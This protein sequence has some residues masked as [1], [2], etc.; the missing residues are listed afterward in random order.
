M[1]QELFMKARRVEKTVQEYFA[2]SNDN[3]VQAKSLMKSFVKKGIFKS[4]N[5]EGQPIRDLLRDL[6]RQ[7]YLKLVPSVHFEQ[8]EKNK[9]W[10]FLRK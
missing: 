7:G 3:K 2:S 4:D 9:N 1:D 10:F 5:K 6:D 8:K